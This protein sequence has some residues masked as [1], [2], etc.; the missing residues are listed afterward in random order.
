[1]VAP[2]RPLIDDKIVPSSPTAEQIALLARHLPDFA[3]DTIRGAGTLLH[4]EAPEIV[5]RALEALAGT[6]PRRV[7]PQRVI[8]AP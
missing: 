5:V 3:T 4:A 2:V 6:G 1:M 7:S 8:P